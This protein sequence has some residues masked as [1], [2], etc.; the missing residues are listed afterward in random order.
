[1]KKL[2]CSPKFPNVTVM[3]LDRAQEMDAHLLRKEL[4]RLISEEQ[5]LVAINQVMDNLRT[6][7]EMPIDK[8]E[9]LTLMM[10][11][12]E[13]YELLIETKGMM[14]EATEEVTE[15]YNQKT[16]LSFLTDLMNWMET[17]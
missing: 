9:L 5:T 7:P 11:T 17:K 14:I 1:M 2:F 4:E 3:K 10:E 8:D 15:E 12:D 16:L 6:M 13:I